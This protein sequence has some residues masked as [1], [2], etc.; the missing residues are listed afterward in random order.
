MNHPITDS[1]NNGVG[2][3]WTSIGEPLHIPDRILNDALGMRGLVIVIVVFVALSM[4][5]ARPHFIPR[6]S[7]PLPPVNVP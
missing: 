3:I 6:P 5:G 1:D 4:V 2:C 7:G